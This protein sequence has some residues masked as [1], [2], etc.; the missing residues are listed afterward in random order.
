MRQAIIHPTV[1]AIPV[2]AKKDSF[3][4]DPRAIEPEIV[5]AG[6]AAGVVAP[7]NNTPEA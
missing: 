3:I 7:Q 6:S 2:P 1:P 5:P 4:T